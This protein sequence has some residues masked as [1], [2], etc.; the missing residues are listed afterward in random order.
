M[1]RKAEVRKEAGRIIIEPVRKRPRYTLEDLVAQCDRRKRRSREE[2]EWL[3]A[4]P[5]GREAL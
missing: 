2:R 4:P 1:V 5:V 3:D